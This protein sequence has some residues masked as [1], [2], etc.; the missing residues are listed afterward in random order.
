MAVKK[1]TNVKVSSNTLFYVK[2]DTKLEAYD[3][4]SSSKFA[5]QGNVKIDGNLNTSDSAGKNFVNEFPE[6][7]KYGQLIIK[8][9]AQSNSGK[10]SSEFKFKSALAWHPLALPYKG[11]TAGDVVKQAFGVSSVDGAFVKYSPGRGGY[12]NGYDEERY[13]NAIF[14]WNN[15]EHGFE[16]LEE[17]S[18]IGAMM[19]DAARYYA[20]TK[21]SSLHE[22]NNEKRSLSGI[23]V[24]QN[25]TLTLNSYTIDGNRKFNKWGEAYGSYIIDFTQAMP[26]DWSKYNERQV[27]QEFGSNIF[28]LGNPYTSNIDLKALV[29]QSGASAKILAMVQFTTQNYNDAVNQ[30][31]ASNSYGVKMNGYTGQNTGDEKFR[32]VRPLQTFAIKTTGS[33]NL[34]FNDKV[35]TFK[36]GDNDSPTPNVLYLKNNNGGAMF[37]Q[38]GLDLYDANGET[39][40]RTYVVA[41]DVQPK[42]GADIIELY[43][44]AMTDENTG[45]YTLQDNEEVERRGEGKLYI[46]GVNSETYVGKPVALVMQNGKGQYRLKARLNGDAKASANKFYFEDKNTGKIQEIGEN[47]DYEFTSTGTEKDRFVVYWGQVPKVND[48][49]ETAKK[50]TQST[51]VFKDGN[52]FKVRF[53]KGIKN[54]DVFVYNISGQLLSVAKNVDATK[55]YVVPVQANTTVYVVKVVGDNG[56]VVTKKIIK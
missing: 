48:V 40:N 49:A 14:F 29:E 38:V 11:I 19:G 2:G 17:S 44:I 3:S 7:A 24:N 20:I 23:P 28:Y 35:K 26:Q 8:Q 10:I 5:N 36:S 4:G 16:Q 21:F 27:N 32:Y 25:F 39:G 12:A 34:N 9:D 6:T 56:S 52:D 51:L 42:E 54:A 1:N 13:K 55:D 30:G 15:S 37:A 43:N 46:N 47:F 18:P 45:I 50:A 31:N 33:V 22:L 41:S 53:D